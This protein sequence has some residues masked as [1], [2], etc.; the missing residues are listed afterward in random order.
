[1]VAGCQV[2]KVLRLRCSMDSCLDLSPTCRGDLVPYILKGGVFYR[3]NH[4]TLMHMLKMSKWGEGYQ[5]PTIP[6]LIGE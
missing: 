2:L 1:M 4:H 3:C 6:A 5:V